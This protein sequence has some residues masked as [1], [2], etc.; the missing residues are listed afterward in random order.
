[1]KLYHEWNVEYMRNSSSSSWADLNAVDVVLLSVFWGVFWVL[2]SKI[3][4]EYA[5]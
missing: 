3:N 5:F 4:F 1:M 2:K